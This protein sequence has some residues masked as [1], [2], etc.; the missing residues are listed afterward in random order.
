MAEFMGNDI[1]K[2]ESKAVDVLFTIWHAWVGD[3]AILRG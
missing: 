2:E 1:L 3:K